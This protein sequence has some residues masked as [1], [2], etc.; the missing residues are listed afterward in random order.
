[1]RPL[2]C[3]LL[4][5]YPLV[6][7]TVKFYLSKMEAVE[8]VGTE[9]DPIKA[10]KAISSGS[11]KADVLLLDIEMPDVDGMAV[12]EALNHK[13]K[14]IFLSSFTE[15]GFEAFSK[16]AVDFVAKP[17]DHE[18]LKLAIEKARQL[19]EL[20]EY[21]QNRHI[22]LPGKHLGLKARVSF[23]DI[24]YIEAFSNYHKVYLV[25]GKV[26]IEHGSLSSFIRKLPEREFIRVSRFYIIN[27]KHFVSKTP[28]KVIMSDGN[29]IVIGPSYLKNLIKVITCK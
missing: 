24:L 11:V 6:F 26:I 13:I 20:E 12:A 21:K 4:D 5:D 9:T 27:L 16:N 1:M 19:I 22:F 8:I 2:K 17:V 28:T 23:D 7:K 25:T 10:I 14:I 18:K 15:Y 29:S 3:Y